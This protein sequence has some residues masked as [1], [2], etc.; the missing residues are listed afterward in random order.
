MVNCRVTWQ[1]LFHRPHLFHT[2][3]TVLLLAEVLFQKLHVFLTHLTR[4][5]LTGEVMR[6]NFC[7]W[8]LPVDDAHIDADADVVDNAVD[9]AHIDDKANDNHPCAYL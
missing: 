4:W 3:C 7:C 9:D 2:L 6:A 5:T 8:Q 1:L